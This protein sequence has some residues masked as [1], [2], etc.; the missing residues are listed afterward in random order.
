MWFCRSGFFFTA[1]L[2]F[3]AGILSA[4]SPNYYILLLLRGLVGI[5]LAG[6][7]VVTSWFLEFIPT[8]NRGLWMVVISLF[9]TI[10]TMAEATLAWVHFHLK[11]LSYVQ[12]NNRK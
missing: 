2:T 12:I 9:W 3:G 1:T 6:G 8:S 5:G 10:G 7:T 4:L 11:S